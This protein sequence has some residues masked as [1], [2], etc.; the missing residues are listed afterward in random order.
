MLGH[1]L[2]IQI[3]FLNIKQTTKLNGL[4]KKNKNKIFI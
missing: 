4:N 3:D 1:L 2:Q